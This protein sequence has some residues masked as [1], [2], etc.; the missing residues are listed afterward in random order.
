MAASGNVAGR[1][2]IVLHATAAEIREA[3]VRFAEHTGR[4]LDCRNLRGVSAFARYLD[5]P[6]LHAGRLGGLVEKSIRWHGQIAR[7]GLEELLEQTDLPPALKRLDTPTVAPNFPIPEDPRIR[8]LDTVGSILKEGRDMGHC[9]AS[10]AATAVAARAFL[11]RRVDGQKATVELEPPRQVLEAAGPRNSDNEAVRWG[12]QTLA[13]CGE[14][15]L[16]SRVNRGPTPLRVYVPVLAVDAGS[17]SPRS[18]TNEPA[19]RD[20]I[21][22]KSIEAA[23]YRICDCTIVAETFPPPRLNALLNRPGFSASTPG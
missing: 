7:R 12:C 6:E 21:S 16:R 23:R 15:H 19:R 13:E 3:V 17:R 22:P 10:L 8:F 2:N 11:P 14:R 9:V 20:P 1:I 5:F 4:Q 18:F